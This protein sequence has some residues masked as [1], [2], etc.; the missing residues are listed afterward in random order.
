[1]TNREREILKIIEKN[2]LI[3]QKELASILGVSRAAIA[4]HI[5]NLFR[6]GYIKGRGYLL[7][8]DKIV[9]VI[10]AINID[11]I[12]VPEEE[13]LLNNS[14]PGKIEHYLGG[15]GRNT[16][17]SLTKLGISNNFISVYGK[18]AYG[19][20]FVNDSQLNN[21]D[22]ECCERIEGENTSS[23]LYFESM[24]ENE[25]F[26]IDDMDIIK[27]ITPTFINR[28]LDRINNSTYCVF[29]DSLSE[30]T[31]EYICNHVTIP[32]IVKS[33]SLNKIDRIFNV[34]DKIDTLII[35]FE[36][37]KLIM[38]YYNEP[39]NNL[40]DAGKFIREKNV[41]NLIV[42]SI[43]DGLFFSS[44]KE[45]YNVKREVVSK[46]NLNGTTAV[47]T[48]VVIWGLFYNHSWE[49]I[50]KYAYEGALLSTKTNESVHPDFSESFL[51]SLEN[52]V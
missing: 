40:E 21:L 44:E 31:I 36:E 30:E 16:A 3:S 39:Y 37:L 22:I 38:S 52:E 15:V 45:S 46:Y 28:Y 26:G 33:V 35:T 13:I 18:D 29:D 17:L 27:N 5:H 49:V 34:L 20:A 12:G 14:N 48:A 2:P 23:Y 50:L 51:S 9:S 8:K 7:N 11:I 4:T 6:K 47:F 41:K 24:H 42:F 1:M 25:K 10:G 32:L 43:K 19:E